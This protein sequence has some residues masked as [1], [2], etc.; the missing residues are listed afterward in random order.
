MR[1]NVF[2]SA[3]RYLVG[4]EYGFFAEGNEQWFYTLALAITN[5]LA[6]SFLPDIALIFTLLSIIHLVT[7]HIYG[8][9]DLDDANKIISIGYFAIHAI[10]VIIALFTNWWWT[11]VTAFIA[12]FALALAPD[13]LGENVFVK[14]KSGYPK[15]FVPLIFNTF[16]FIAFV[17]STCMLPIAWW[18]KVLIVIAAIILHPFIDYLEG[19]CVVVTDVTQY[20]IDKIKNEH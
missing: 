10:I 13:C 9:Y 11:L 15:K 5:M 18:G 3:L 12:L 1:D 19:E 17:V 4:C 7:V 16:I 2:L 20:A 14:S 6:W 8:Y